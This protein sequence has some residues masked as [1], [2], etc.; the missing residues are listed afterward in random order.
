M[1]FDIILHGK[2]NAGCHKV[3]KG[4]DDSFCQNLVENFMQSMGYIKEAETL[5]VDVRNWNNTWYSVYTFWLGGNIIDTAGRPSFI[6]LSIVVQN[7]YFCL[8]SA[9][10][11]M[12]KKAFQNNIIDTYIS[13]KGEYL[14]QNFD[15][16]SVFERLVNAINSN[17]VNLSEFIDNSFKQPHN[18][19]NCCYSLLDCD[20]KA[21]VEDWKKYGRI[22]V[23]K[24]YDSKDKRLSNTDKYY[25]ELQKSKNEL[26]SKAQE[27]KQLTARIKELDALLSSGNSKINK[28][29]AALKEQVK[30]LDSEKKTLKQNVS[31]LNSE[32]ERHRDIEKQITNILGSIAVD[33]C[34]NPNK[35][36]AIPHRISLKR[37]IPMINMVLLISLLF[38]T[39]FKSCG[40]QINESL[41]E[42]EQTANILQQKIEELNKII[43]EKDDQ[44]RILKSNSE[45]LTDN[46]SD[47]K[48]KNCDLTVYQDGKPVGISEIDFN[49]EI[50]IF[51][52][53]QNGY[54]FY[55]SNL[56]S[57]NVQ[58]GVPFKLE[59]IVKSQPI[60]ITYRS[61]D[62]D[63]C[64]QHNV[65]T[66]K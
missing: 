38:A 3:T 53:T 40:S 34:D 46:L 30:V 54:A 45:Y 64:N 50:T 35:E 11:E 4:L 17:I 32:N 5:I 39:T 52:Q 61:Q 36:E 2:P 55:T 29:L 51:V 25:K 56:K 10:Y 63:K 57:V 7:H 60:I 21:F 24:T 9:I 66:I 37:I 33:S 27:I 62:R 12:L 19:S 23:S 42:E 59:K 16:D 18:D 49:K 47:D 31:N 20:S 41:D 43:T 14:V 22:F 15:N 26:Q 65:V 1:K 8:V 48:D 13:V 58:N 44:I 28:T 6:A